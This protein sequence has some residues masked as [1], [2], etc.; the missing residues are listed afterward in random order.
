MKNFISSQ[1]TE[2]QGVRIT[3]YKFNI[4]QLRNPNL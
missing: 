4:N 3:E 2:K 1:G